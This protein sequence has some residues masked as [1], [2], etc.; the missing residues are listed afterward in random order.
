MGN[1]QYVLWPLAAWVLFAGLAL[2]LTRAGVSLD[3]DSAMRLV[4]VRDLLHGQNWFDTVQHR[5]NTPYGLPMHWSRLV[6][7]P[8][9]PLMLVSEKFAVVAWPLLLFLAAL[10]LL[11]RIA[12]VMA[13]LRAVVTAMALALLCSGLY[14]A[15]APGNIDHHGLQLVLMLAA[16]LCVIE[17]RPAL[18]A[19]A[20]ALG[21]GVG[22]ESLPYALAAI[23]FWAF[24]QDKSRAFGVTLAGMALLLLAASTAA[25]YRFLAVCDT[26]SLFYA[27]L[28]AVGGA[29]L[30]AIS[31]LPRHRLA[32]L[33]VLALALL[34]LAAM[35][36]PACLA[37]PYAGMDARMRL[38]FLDR[39]NEARPVWSFFRLAPAQVIGGY[40]YAV[41]ALA[42]CVLAPPGR[43]RVAVMGFAVVALLVAT[44][45][46]RGVNFALLF[47]LPGLAAALVRLTARRSVVWLAAAILVANGG[48]FTLAGAIGEG[49]DKVRLRAMRFGAQEEC[50]GRFAMEPLTALPP[51]RVAA[52]VD[53][54]PAILAYTGDSAIAGPYHRDAAGIL[55][56]YE[57]FAGKDPRA[58]LK[59]RGIDYVMVCRAA[60]DW[61]FYRAK[62]GLVSQLA[63]R[64][65]PP[66]LSYVDWRMAFELPPIAEVYRVKR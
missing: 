43:A 42:M 46:Y 51:G 44:F 5:M 13:G 23:A 12:F 61:D 25:P 30:A 6:D 38:I 8:L 31:F 7:A 39:I 4:Q 32:A 65:T 16:L 18:G 34:A 41:F 56:T 37:G 35:L 55:D 53:Q 9:A 22:L 58:V 2:W 17:R 24:D 57:I 36:G 19:V 21:L 50:G 59:R 62:G 10:L 66:W 1:R 20:V 47:A 52:F 49:P 40:L 48:A 60:P 14:A 3:T 15:F 11:A 45:Q 29:G 26:Y 27:A 64:K 33:I 63:E 28:L 54:G